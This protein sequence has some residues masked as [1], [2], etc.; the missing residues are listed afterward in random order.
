MMSEIFDLWDISDELG[1]F[2]R[3]YVDCCPGGS[4]TRVA[5]VDID[6]VD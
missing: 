3:A 5:L 1:V 6:G 4:D 2:R